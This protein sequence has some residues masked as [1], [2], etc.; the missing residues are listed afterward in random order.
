MHY[1]NLGP[2]AG[3]ALAYVGVMQGGV[4]HFVLDGTR[5]G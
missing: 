2:A 4:M 5:Q 1:D 3:P